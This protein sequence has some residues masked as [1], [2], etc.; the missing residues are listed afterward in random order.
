LAVGN[1]AG[2]AQAQGRLDEASRLHADAARRLAAHD[3]PAAPA[4]AV[5][6]S[7]QAYTE[8]L[9]GRLAE[10]EALYRRAVPVLDSAWRGTPRIAPTLVDFGR[11]L[12]LRAKCV[13]SEGYLRRALAMV[14]ARNAGDADL[15]RTQRVLGGCLYDLGRYPAAESLMVA[16][17]RSLQTYWGDTNRYTIDAAADLARLYRKWG[18]P[19]D[20]ARFEAAH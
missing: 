14:E 10:S 5:A 8:L 4:V 3:G 11:L 9:R 6:V 17:H 1:L 15:I 16:A 7:N 18:R 20:A 12:R 19:E 2:Y 13:E